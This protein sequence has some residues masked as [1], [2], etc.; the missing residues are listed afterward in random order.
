MATCQFC[1]EYYFPAQSNAIAR[2]VFCSQG[3]EAANHA[4]D[5]WNYDERD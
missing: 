4:L 2:E 5:E 1:D 3:C